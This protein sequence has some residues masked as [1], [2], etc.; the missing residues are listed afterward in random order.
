MV[1][2]L[3]RAPTPATCGRGSAICHADAML[4]KDPMVR[5]VILFCVIV[6]IVLPLLAA[7]F[8]AVK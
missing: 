7:L 1:A 3:E 4:P 6:S 5:G 8:F 2:R